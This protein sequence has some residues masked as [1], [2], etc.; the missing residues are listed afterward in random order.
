M[1]AAVR[2]L[3]PLRWAMSKTFSKLSIILRSCPRWT[4]SRGHRKAFRVL[5]AAGGVG[6]GDDLAAHLVEEPGGVAPDVAISLD[7]ERRA[8][9][10]LAELAEHLA[11][12]QGDPIA[13]G[14]LAAGRAVELD[15]LAGD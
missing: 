13:G 10:H 8:G 12:D 15:R 6:D 4:C 7:G 1:N 14:G 3:T 5:E 11:R 2:R 9:D